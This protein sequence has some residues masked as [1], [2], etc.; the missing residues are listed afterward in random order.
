MATPG[1]KLS[2]KTTPLNSTVDNQSPLNHKRH[3]EIFHTPVPT[4]ETDTP[5]AMETPDPP[6]ETPSYTTPLTS[7]FPV[8]NTLHV[9][10]S[11][12]SPFIPIQIFK[13]RRSR[14]PH[15]KRLAR[16]GKTAITTPK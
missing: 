7:E 14:R 13:P 2:I 11:T 8:E 16:I 3:I 12:A 4:V 5:Y 6:V 1:L 10:L 9:L 15:K